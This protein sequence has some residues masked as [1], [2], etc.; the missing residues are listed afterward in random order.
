MNGLQ[1]RAAFQTR[2]GRCDALNR[3]E[4]PKLDFDFDFWVDALASAHLHLNAAAGS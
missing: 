1:R 3:I 4:L 2:K